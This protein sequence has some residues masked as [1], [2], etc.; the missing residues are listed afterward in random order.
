M[1]QPGQPDPSRGPAPQPPPVPPQPRP[2]PVLEGEVLPPLQDSPP[3][4]SQPYAAPQ[5]APAPQP[6]PKPQPGPVPPAEAPFSDNLAVAVAMFL[7]FPPFALPATIDARRARIAYRAG[8]LG[9]AQDNAKESRRWTRAAVVAG[10]ICW[11]LVVCCGIGRW[12]LRAIGLPV[13]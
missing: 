6:G 5:P 8:Q 9:V 11:A 4:M 12:L 10:P 3:P 7:L 1:T 13:P 2:E